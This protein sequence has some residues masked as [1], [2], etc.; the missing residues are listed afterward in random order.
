MSLP[1][2]NDLWVVFQYEAEMFFDMCGLLQEGN[3]DFAREGERG[4]GKGDVNFF[5]DADP[6]D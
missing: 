1:T 6:A 5:L 4:T 2:T 3:A